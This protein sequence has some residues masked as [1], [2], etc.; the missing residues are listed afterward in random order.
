MFQKEG[1]PKARVLLIKSQLRTQNNTISLLSSLSST[2]RV[3]YCCHTASG[4][5]ANLISCHQG[6]KTCSGSSSE[7]RVFLEGCPDALSL[8]YYL[9]YSSSSRSNCSDKSLKELTALPG[10]KQP[11]VSSLSP[12]SWIA[13]LLELIIPTLTTTV[14]MATTHEKLSFSLT[15]P[16]LSA[17]EVSYTFLMAVTH[18]QIIL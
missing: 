2:A 10:K 17:E 9:P 14:W 16:L 4:R 3:M 11:Q 6:L 1:L 7:E 13:F 8:L 18:F 15:S 12:S 5:W